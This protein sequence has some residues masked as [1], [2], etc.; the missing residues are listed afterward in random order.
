MADDGGARK[1][2]RHGHMMNEKQNVYIHKSRRFAKMKTYNTERKCTKNTHSN[3]K[4][5]HKG[6]ENTHFV[7][8]ILAATAA[9]WFVFHIMRRYLRFHFVS[10]SLLL[11]EQKSQ[12]LH[13]HI[14][15]REGS[16]S[17]ALTAFNLIHLERNGPECE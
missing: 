6:V 15:R 10:M 2:V 16:F 14:C 5:T 17:C 8:T 9:E 13:T 12:R 1:R 3:T 11:F 7:W 4:D